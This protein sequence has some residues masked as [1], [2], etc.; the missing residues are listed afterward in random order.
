M[1]VIIFSDQALK[2][3]KKL[4][5]ETARRII[6]TIERCRINPHSHVMK[7]VASPYTRLRVGDYRVIID[8]KDKEL[9][10]M[11]IGVGH[12]RNAYQDF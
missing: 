3:L 6:S 1:Y 12:R 8:I 7:L 11:V 10:I 5:K 2:Q 4:D 9:I